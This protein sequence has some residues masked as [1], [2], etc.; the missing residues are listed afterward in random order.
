[1]SAEEKMESCLKKEVGDMQEF[2]VLWDI[3]FPILLSFKS[4]GKSWLLYVT[5]FSYFA[6]KVE[7]VLSR[8][9][10]EAIEGMLSGKQSIREVLLSYP[11]TVTK[12][13]MDL[14]EQQMELGEENE[15]DILALL[16]DTQFRLSPDIPNCID[17]KRDL[18]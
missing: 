16:P 17:V 18:A 14:K 1:M 6:R 4:S 7:V 13:T 10:D 15:A 2:R 12:W 3:N 5:K 9:D 11:K 8:A